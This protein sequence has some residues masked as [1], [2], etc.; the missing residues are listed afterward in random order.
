METVIWAVPRL[1][2]VMKMVILT[3]REL[4]KVLITVILVAPMLPC[5]MAEKG[6]SPRERVL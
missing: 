5:V 4:S 6:K 3:V 2:K 1:P